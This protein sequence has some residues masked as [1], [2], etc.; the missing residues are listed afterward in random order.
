MSTRHFS[1]KN[2]EEKITFGKNQ[3]FRE[4]K[5]TFVKIVESLVERH[6]I[7]ENIRLDLFSQKIDVDSG[8]LVSFV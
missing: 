6:G 4:E 2:R 8:V 5:I 7:G 3:F 1:K